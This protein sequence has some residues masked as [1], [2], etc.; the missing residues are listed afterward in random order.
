MVILFREEADYT[1]SCE[2]VVDYRIDILHHD[3]NTEFLV[4]ARVIG[5]L[6]AIGAV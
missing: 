1:S 4:R 5:E 3:V 2:P 6:E